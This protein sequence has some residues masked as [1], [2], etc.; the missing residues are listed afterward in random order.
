M[1]D[2]PPTANIARLLGVG[3]DG[4]E[5]T[6]FGLGIDVDFMQDVLSQ[7]GNFDEVYERTLG[8]IGLARAGSLNDS[9]LRGGI[10]YAPPMR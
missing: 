7:V 9:W 3:F 6:D 1:A 8:A 10:I 5:A 4:G 2:D